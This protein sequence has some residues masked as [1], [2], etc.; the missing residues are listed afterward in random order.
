[1]KDS[2]RTY[3]EMAREVFKFLSLSVTGH[4]LTKVVREGLEELHR[5]RY[6]SGE[7]VS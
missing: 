5:C 6:V 2:R 3:T 1:M 7:G 4:P